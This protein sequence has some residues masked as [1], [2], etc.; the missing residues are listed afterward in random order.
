MSTSTPAPRVSSPRPPQV[1]LEK[2]LRDG[3]STLWHNKS[4][5]TGSRYAT[6]NTK[7]GNRTPTSILENNEHRPTPEDLAATKIQKMARLTLRKRL[8]NSPNRR[9]IERAGVN[10]ASSLSQGIFRSIQV[11]LLRLGWSKISGIALSTFMAGYVARRQFVD[12]VTHVEVAMVLEQPVPR[13]AA[14]CVGDTGGDVALGSRLGRDRSGAAGQVDSKEVQKHSLL[15]T[16][17][18]EDRT[19]E[20]VFPTTHLRRAVARSASR[21]AWNARAATVASE[22]PMPAV[23]WASTTVGLLPN[24]QPASILSE[25]KSTTPLD[26]DASHPSSAQHS[27]KSMPESS[28]ARYDSRILTGLAVETKQA[29]LDGAGHFLRTLFAPFT[30]SQHVA[31]ASKHQSS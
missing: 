30:M 31:G 9:L 29:V 7:T 19:L 20:S 11:W 4:S 13:Q 16:P 23:R 17:L 2:M 18:C 10:V 15:W 3:G 24:Q 27:G 25:N 1:F 6:T 14:E 5:K 21:K 26:T 8:F 12:L 28:N 22:S